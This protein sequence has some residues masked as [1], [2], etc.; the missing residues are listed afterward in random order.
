MEF[1]ELLTG[2]QTVQVSHCSSYRDMTLNYSGFKKLFLN[3]FFIYFTE[4][5]S[6]EV[7]SDMIDMT[8]C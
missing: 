3:S 5:T 6:Y 8:V 4:Q 1:Q 7:R 2:R